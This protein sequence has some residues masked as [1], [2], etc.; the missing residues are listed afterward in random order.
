M[1]CAFD[2]NVLV[3]TVG[4]PADPRRAR[5]RDLMIRG[6]RNGNAVLL[7]QSL[8]EFSSVAIR[9]LGIGADQVSRRV[10]AWSSVTPVQHPALEDVVTAL[11]I[12]RDHQLSFW[13]ALLCA[14]ATR[15]GVRY[16]LTED[17]QD[18]RSI[19]G[20]SL[21]NPFVPGNDALIDRILPG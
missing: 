2:T 6:M 17:L 1:N 16:L 12:L 10:Q 5:A 3:Y 8:A 13:D 4:P 14:T 7:L 20:M 19:L 21:L 15:A 9:K 18:G 11:Q